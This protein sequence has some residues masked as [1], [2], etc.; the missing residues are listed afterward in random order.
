MFLCNSLEWHNFVPRP[1]N[2][3]RSPQ[4]RAEMLCRKRNCRAALFHCCGYCLFLSSY[5]FLNKSQVLFASTL[6]ITIDLLTGVIW[7]YRSVNSRS[8]RRRVICLYLDGLLLGWSRGDV[9]QLWLSSRQERAQVAQSP[10]SI[11][12]SWRPYWSTSI[13]TLCTLVRHLLFDCE[14]DWCRVRCW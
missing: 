10:I 11:S 13:K 7:L 3:N 1:S 5:V 4:Q 9:L 2:N 14:S 12:R 6:T 8:R